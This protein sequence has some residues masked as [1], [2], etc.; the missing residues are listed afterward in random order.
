[1]SPN[2]ALRFSSR[3]IL[4][5]VVEP[6][7]TALREALPGMPA[8]PSI[9]LA[10]DVAQERANAE[11]EAAKRYLTTVIDR[12]QAQRVSAE[13][14]IAEGA[15]AP[16]IVRYASDH[17]ADLIAMSTHGRGGMARLV[18]GSVADE[19]LRSAACPVLLIRSHLDSQ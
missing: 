3:V 7:S 11:H 13:A 18:F 9:E 6:Y 5:R 12:L 14:A 4:L 16:E 17:G 10:A 19:V 2:V 15:P 1:M 8:W